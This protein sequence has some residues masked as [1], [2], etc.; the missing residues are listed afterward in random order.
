MGRKIILV[1]DPHKAEDGSEVDAVSTRTIRLDDRTVEVDLCPE[2]DNTLLVTL[3]AI[4]NSGREIVVPEPRKRAARGAS[5]SG[6]PTQS[7]EIRSWCARQDPPIQINDR[8]RV[9]AEIKARYLAARRQ[10]DAL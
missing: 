4:F 7:R 6:K 2:H 5:S 8:G 10:S 9:P 3:A 1:C